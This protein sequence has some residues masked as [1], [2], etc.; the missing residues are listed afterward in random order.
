[1]RRYPLSS[2]PDS[3][4][5][6][7][8][9][10]GRDSGGSGRSYR[11]GMGAQEQSV[12][13]A[14]ATGCTGQEEQRGSKSGKRSPPLGLPVGVGPAKNGRR[15]T[16]PQRSEAA[17]GSYRRTAKSACDLRCPSPL[18]QQ[19]TH[20]AWAASCVLGQLPPLLGCQQVQDVIIQQSVNVIG[21][22]SISPISPRSAWCARRTRDSAVLCG[23]P[24][25]SPIS[26]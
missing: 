19:E 26:R 23:M 15:N 14:E 11:R 1:M 9:W 25:I 12:E 5:A 22:H 20:A 7:R 8:R 2:K 21:R 17:R 24:R 16:G 6:G 13:T 10:R 18:A 4:T 3:R